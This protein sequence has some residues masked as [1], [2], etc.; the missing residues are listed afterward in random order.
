[1]SE[2]VCRHESSSSD[3]YEQFSNRKNCRNKNTVMPQ[4]ASEWTKHHL[5][6][7]GVYYNRVATSLEEFMSRIHNNASD[8]NLPPLP[9]ICRKLIEFT[10]NIWSVNLDMREATLYDVI[11]A[12]K[13]SDECIDKLRLNET[14]FKEQLPHQNDKTIFEVWKTTLLCFWTNLKRA[15]ARWSY[16]GQT[17]GSFKHLFMLF[18]RICL[19]DP[20][21][22]GAYSCIKQI[23]GIDVCSIPDVRFNTLP[24][25][26][27]LMLI[28]TKVKKYDAFQGDFDAE[29]FC[30]DNV[31][32]DVLGQHGMELIVEAYDSALAPCVLGI[33]CI[34]TKIIFT[35]LDISKH[36]L[37]KMEKS[38]SDKLRS[39][40]SYTRPFDYMDVNDRRD[41][42]ETLFWLGYVQSGSYRTFIAEET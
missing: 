39:I 31:V 10:D 33:I 42:L 9:D 35:Y 38:G 18:S 17:E 32:D 19:L 24:E 2:A 16:P 3:E 4:N 29:S 34:G 41:I 20:Q 40:I 13:K 27:H 30:A 22:G 23:R 8:R 6:K 12:G 11:Q 26:G 5:Q 28:V 21:P 14:A 15:L 7:I 37:S 36:H 25:D 1:M